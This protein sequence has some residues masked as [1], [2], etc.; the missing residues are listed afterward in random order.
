L[1]SDYFAYP[2]TADKFVGYGQLT[3]LTVKELQET[4]SFKIDYK[5]LTLS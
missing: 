2:V 5:F 4:V 1:N 3:D